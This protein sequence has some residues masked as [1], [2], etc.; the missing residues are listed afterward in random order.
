MTSTAAPDTEQ[1]LLPGH[2]W[3]E[4]VKRSNEDSFTAAF[5]KDVVLDASVLTA[6]IIGVPG[7]RRFFEA[8][9]GMYDRIAFTGETG[10]GARTCLEWEGTF[11]GRNVA[12][13]TTLTRDA[14]DAITSIR[15]YHRPYDQVVAFSAELARRLA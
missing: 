7:V 13:V 11:E 6:P 4:I 1:P 9:R 2:A 5:A 8:T 12:G 14:T 3:L 10:E 15:L